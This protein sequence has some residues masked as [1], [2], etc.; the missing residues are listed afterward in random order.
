MQQQDQ[1]IPAEQVEQ[2]SFQ[3]M[4]KKHI[5]LLPLFLFLPPSIQTPSAHPLVLNFSLA[6]PFP[7][8]H[9]LAFFS[10]VS[11]I[12]LIPVTFFPFSLC[13]LSV[14][15]CDCLIFIGLVLF[16]A[17]QIFYAGLVLLPMLPVRC[18]GLTLFHKV[19]R[20]SLKSDGITKTQYPHPQNPSRDKTENDAQS[21]LKA[22]A[23][24]DNGDE[25]NM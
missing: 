6:H 9:P 13:S 4:E 19:T 24:T 8:Y 17:L 22:L 15:L 20:P 5:P 11:S 21:R 14:A 16:C 23:K 18:A 25:I 3:Q 7:Q 12:L 1:H 2:T 10:H